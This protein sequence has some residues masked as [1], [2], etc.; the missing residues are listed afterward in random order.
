MTI[1]A[2]GDLNPKL[3]A[4]PSGAVLVP[5]TDSTRSYC[6]VTGSVVTNPATGK[7]ANFGLALP[8]A[9][10]EKLLFT[11]CSGYCGVVFQNLPDATGGGYPTH[12]LAKGYAIAATDA[13]HESTPAGYL[14]DVSW[15]L[16]APGVPNTDATTDY[17]HRAVHTVTV[18]AKRFVQ[19]WYSG[20]LARAY[21]F[22]C[23]GGGREGMME[24]ARYPTDF[25]GYIVGAPSFDV[26]GEILSGRGSMALLSATD[27]YIAP[28][29]LS[30]VDNSVYAHCD[31]ADGVRDRLIQN[32][33]RCSFRPETLLCRGDN[34]VACLTRSQVRTLKT[35]FA[36][37]RDEKGR[38]VSHGSPVSDMYNDGAPGNNLFE[39]LAAPGPA[40]DIHAVSPW[41]A[42]PSQQPKAWASMDQALKYLVHWDPDFNTRYKPPVNAGGIVSDKTLEL[43]AL[44]TDRGS[45]DT[46]SRL[47]PFLASGRKLILY[48]GYSDGWVSP[49]RTLR[50]YRNWSKRVG[51]H[52]V[53]QNDARLFTVPGMYHC[54]HGPG[55]N[56]F[57]ALGALE[58]WVE[59]G[60]PPDSII[61]TKHENDEVTGAPIRSMPLCPFPTQASY[62]GEGDLNASES[63]SCTPNERLL[64]VGENGAAAGLRGPA[65]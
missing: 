31:E 3:P 35:W 45:A 46:P 36:A 62:A 47:D 11:G 33:G 57:D 4:A 6:L 10:N 26:P 2:I 8:A 13:G 59:Q 20:D 15:A 43:L 24:A 39:W 58:Q 29:L 48:H 61:A 23:S 18:Q 17:F 41:G 32:P 42:S 50:F 25:D 65:R 49:F 34:G 30:L 22:G 56:V 55:P 60:V 16:S 21:Y 52:G 44:R 54:S 19:S 38:V 40:R 37:A 53:L 27:S 5:E 14:Y 12:A 64:Y 28:E 51:G 63:W 1:K 7:T 9:W